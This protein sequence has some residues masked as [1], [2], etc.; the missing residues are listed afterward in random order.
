MNR[1]RALCTLRLRCCSG[2]VETP[3]GAA[4]DILCRRQN[5]GDVLLFSV[6]LTLIV[7]PENL[8]PYDNITLGG[9]LF[10]SR[11]LSYFILLFYLFIF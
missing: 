5:G 7:K 6:M 9:S 11:F 10:L 1:V 4:G 8:N 3:Q 2:D